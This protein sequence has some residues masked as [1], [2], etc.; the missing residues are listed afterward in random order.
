MFGDFEQEARHWVKQLRSGGYSE[1]E[2]IA[3]ANRAFQES[4]RLQQKAL[5]AHRAGRPEEAKA[6][7]AEAARLR[8]EAS[9]LVSARAGVS[10]E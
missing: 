6:L 10:V 3:A 2:V 9:A 4:L 7:E 5:H 8:D 1:G